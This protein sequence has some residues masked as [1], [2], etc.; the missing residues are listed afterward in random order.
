MDSNAGQRKITRRVKA[1]IGGYHGATGWRDEHVRKIEKKFDRSVS[2]SVRNGARLIAR[3]IK[4][5]VKTHEERS[6]R[7]GEF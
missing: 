3:A 1:T 2:G 4:K 6:A 7:R 5:R